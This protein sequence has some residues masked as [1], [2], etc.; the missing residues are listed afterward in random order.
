MT[1][2]ETSTVEDDPEDSTMTTTEA[3]AEEA[4]ETMRPRECLKR[5]RRWCVYKPRELTTMS[6]ASSEEDEPEDSATTT[7]PSAEPSAEDKEYTTC[8]RGHIRQRSRP[9][10]GDNN[11]GCGVLMTGPNNW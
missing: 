2:T 6:A 11:G 10:F 3:L 4:E 9:V 8:P 7:E 5:K 1:T